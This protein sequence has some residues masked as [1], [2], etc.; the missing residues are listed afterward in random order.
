MVISSLW[1]YPNHL[2][3]ASTAFLYIVGIAASCGT[4]AGSL[5]CGSS[6]RSLLD[7]SYRWW[8]VLQ[9]VGEWY[10]GWKSRTVCVSSVVGGGL[11]VCGVS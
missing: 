10:Q 11:V 7:T 9:V 1:K 6:R 4:C 5:V 3:T 8:V 2:S